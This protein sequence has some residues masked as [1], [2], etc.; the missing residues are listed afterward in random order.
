MK[1]PKKIQLISTEIKVVFKKQKNDGVY[2]RRNKEISL[3]VDMD[4][5]D[6]WI[7][8]F[9]ELNH[10]KNSVLRDILDEIIKDNDSLDSEE[11]VDLMAQVDY[12]II[13]QIEGK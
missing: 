3:R 6:K 1:I 10:A 5:Q 9:H 12:Q 8:F 11:Y 4:I 13:K 7:A 2:N